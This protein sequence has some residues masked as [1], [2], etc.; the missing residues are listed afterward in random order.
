MGKRGVLWEQQYVFGNRVISHK[1]VIRLSPLQP[2]FLI[3]VS[4][5][6]RKSSEQAE[7]E[8]KKEAIRVIFN[9]DLE[10]SSY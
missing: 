3:C 7:L 4:H 8:K 5:L 1:P 9:T 10:A 6:V 2:F